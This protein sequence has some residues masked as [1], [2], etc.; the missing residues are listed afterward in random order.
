MVTEESAGNETNKQPRL[1]VLYFL[2]L[3]LSN[4]AQQRKRREIYNTTS[5]LK[6][7]IG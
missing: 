2:A 3:T 6:L 1:Q 7:V 4:R 5:N